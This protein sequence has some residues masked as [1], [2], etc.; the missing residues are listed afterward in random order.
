QPRVTPTMPL[1][2]VSLHDALPIYHDEH[3][4]PDATMQS[5]AALQPSFVSLGEFA[6][7]GVAL[8]RYPEVEEITHVHH[9]GNSSG[10]VD[11]ASAA[12]FGNL[13]TGQALGLMPR[14]SSRSKGST[15]S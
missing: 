5:L 9:A 8:A 12:L 15:G 10:I 1:R 13:A 2:T 3:M 7:D 6:F 14:E 11:G 4:R